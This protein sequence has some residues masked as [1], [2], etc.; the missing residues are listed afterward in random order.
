MIGARVLLVLLCL[1][2]IGATFLL[3][4]LGSSIL[5]LDL[6]VIDWTLYEVLEVVSALALLTGSAVSVRLLLAVR[7]RAQRAE[8]AVRAARG[9][10]AQVMRERFDDWALT[11]AERD[12]ATLALKGLSGAEIAALR[13]TSEGTV[14]AQ[15]ASIY[16]KSGTSGRA[17]LLSLFLDELLDA[18]NPAVAVPSP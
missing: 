17:Q 1:Q 18:P 6:P 9:A 3:L 2:G 5:G 14:K 16:R 15:T 10:F 11:P 12:V 8:T 4:E 7:A 13:G